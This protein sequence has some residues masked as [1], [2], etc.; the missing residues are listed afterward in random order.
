MLDLAIDIG[1]RTCLALMAWT[2]YTGPLIS[3]IIVGEW[4]KIR[5]GKV[6]KFGDC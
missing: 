4:V 1:W 2:L 3:V 5:L 6:K